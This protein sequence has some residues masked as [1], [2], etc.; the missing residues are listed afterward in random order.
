M[1]NAANA[2]R[3]RDGNRQAY[4]ELSYACVI[5]DAKS[6]VDW[7]RGPDVEHSR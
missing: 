3:E 6:M 7:K 2:D 5:S 4:D 1:M